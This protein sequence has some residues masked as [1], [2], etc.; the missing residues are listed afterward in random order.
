MSFINN[1]VN[2]FYNNIFII[3][4][5]PFVLVVLI[6]IILIYYVL[7]SSLGKSNSVDGSSKSIG[8]VFIESLLWG[9][10]IL[11]IFFNGFSY[12]FNINISTELKKLFSNEPEITIKSYTENEYDPTN[13]NN[14]ENIDNKEVYHIPG[15]RFTYN[16]AKA[17]CKAFNSDLATFSQIK[18]AQSKGASWCSFGWSQDQLALYPTSQKDFD[19][20]KNKE[21]HEYDCG[22]PGVNGGYVS[23]TYLNLGANCYGVKPKKSSLE[24]FYFDKDNQTYPKTFKEQVFDKRVE[25]WKERIGNIIISPFNNDK[26]F[27]I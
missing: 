27:K 23:N 14:D 18:N 21:G 24:E 22:L 10:L 19:K 20:L 15:N 4:S 1:I 7:F 13:N 11:L 26:W 9:I 25:Y 3:G 6:V 8:F 12:F 16:D 17:V 5:N 2:D